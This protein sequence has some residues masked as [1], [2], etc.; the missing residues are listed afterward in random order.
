MSDLLHRPLIKINENALAR[1]SLLSL[2]LAFLLCIGGPAG[3]APA[4]D[5]PDVLLRIITQENRKIRDSVLG[6]GTY[7]GEEGILLL[8]PETGAALGLVVHHGEAYNEALSLLARADEALSRARGAMSTRGNEAHPGDHAREISTSILEHKDLTRQANERL[9]AYASGLD[10]SV[11][12]RLD[13]KKCEA[14]MTRLLDESLEKTENRLRD[15]L[16]DFANTCAGEKANA[17]LTPENVRFVNSV[18][19]G[20]LNKADPAVA[21]RFDLDKQPPERAAGDVDGWKDAAGNEVADILKHLEAALEKHLQNG[22]HPVDPLLFLALM[23]RESAF[24]PRAISYVGAAGLTQI[25]PKTAEDMG[26]EG[27][28]R[29]DYFDRAFA[30]LGEERKAAREAREAL[31]SVTPENPLEPATRARERMQESLRLQRERKKLFERYRRELAQ[32]HSDPRLDP[33]KAVEYGLRYFSGLMSSQDGDI[34][35]A[36]ASYNA[37]P[38]RVAQYSGIP[39]YKETVR[40]RNRVLEFYREYLERLEQLETTVSSRGPSE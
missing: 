26:M 39:P 1:R 4:A 16:G 34:S 30:V 2:G 35:L 17:S 36:L 14:L 19:Q 7:R 24:D 15:A 6:D 33:R 27:V 21:A 3:E 10:A 9:R 20:F 13:D 23:R 28:F 32:K 29:P 38:H 18:F 22:G 8:R 25:M 40:F 5:I 31:F 37:G 12:E 11:D